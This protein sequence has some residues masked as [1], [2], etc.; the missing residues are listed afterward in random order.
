VTPPPALSVRRLGPADAGLVVAAGDEVFDHAPEPVRT[1]AFLSA[2]LHHMVGAIAGDRLV[3]FVSA[4]EYLHPDKPRALWINE[5]A[6]AEGYRRRG[7]ARAM[8][9]EALVL[10]RGLGCAEAWVATEPGNAAA[11][12]LYARA[13]EQAG[14]EMA[15]VYTFGLEAA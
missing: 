4:V 12:A 3:G 13:A 10:A 9:A 2:P 5:V 6:V 8:L 7:I 1:A 11:R 14:G 15:V